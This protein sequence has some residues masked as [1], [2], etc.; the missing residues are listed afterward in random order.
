MISTFSV[1]IDCMHQRL[2][3]HYDALD[4][5]R[6]P[7][8]APPSPSG[9]RM[10][11]LDRLLS[12]KPMA[13]TT[14]E[15][16][17]I[18]LSKGPRRGRVRL[19]PSPILS[20]KRGPDG[21]RGDSVAPIPLYRPG[22]EHRIAT[23]AGL[24]AIRTLRRSKPGP[25]ASHRPAKLYLV[26]FDW[27]E[28]ARRFAEPESSSDSCPPVGTYS[29]QGGCARLIRCVLESGGL[30]PVTSRAGASLAREQGGWNIVWAT[31]VMKKSS[32]EDGK[33]Y[34][35]GNARPGGSLA[36]A[37]LP[38]ARRSQFPRSSHITRKDALARSVTVLSK[39]SGA[40]RLPAFLPTT[41]ILP[42]EA[43]AFQR[44]C[45]RRPGR[46]WIVKPAASSQGRGVHVTRYG[47]DGC[48]VREES[49]GGAPLPH[50]S[51]TLDLRTSAI[52]SSASLG[53]S[54]VPISSMLPPE[55]L[56]G[57]RS[58]AAGSSFTVSSYVERPLL[59][60][61]FKFDIRLYVAVTSFNPPRVYLHQHGLARFA[62]R[63]YGSASLQDRFVH[64]TNYS[65]NK[66]ADAFREAR[67]PDEAFGHKWGLPAL[68]ERWEADPR[69]G[70]EGAEYLWR[71]I[72]QVAVRTVLAAHSAVVRPAA[73]SGKGTAPS[74]HRE[75]DVEDEEDFLARSCGNA[76][77]LF[78][79]DVLVDESL[80]PWLLEVN[81][82]P[83]MAAEAPLDV[84]IK[85][86]VLSD[87]LNLACIPAN[88]GRSHASAAVA[89]SS[90]EELDRND[91]RSLPWA[92][93]AHLVSGQT[94]DELTDALIAELEYRRRGEYR[95]L[96]P[97]A[98]YPE[99]LAIFSQLIES[100]ELRRRAEAL[101]AYMWKAGKVLCPD[102]PEPVEAQRY[103]T[104]TSIV[105]KTVGDLS[106][107]PESVDELRLN[108]VRAF[109]A[110]T[111][112]C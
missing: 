22:R 99:S 96:M 108:A 38:L 92:V 112:P 90:S 59:L 85:S 83:S 23:G 21:V 58:L 84:E 20:P 91:S 48:P 36:S 105:R 80:Q 52:D 37:A 8:A 94:S 101:C 7:M 28:A 88:R 76:F 9:E 46:L 63:K 70:K 62:T 31:S 6:R 57:S 64:L 68:R 56:G 16:V 53:P 11:L 18:S 26:T 55:L 13:E 100:R 17:P 5:D 29:V 110:W 79:L 33:P 47:A 30:L 51:G 3:E 78:G 50:G 75:D 82:S 25:A 86:R 107:T 45:A 106:F 35:Q 103:M 72:D 42:A 95:R 44:A 27:R 40:I 49:R 104:S 24:A 109:R 89:A 69:I 10:S 71:Q 43:G 111:P 67:T 34:E 41:F 39:R 12:A 60:D 1:R 2:A 98:E 73:S 102:G 54:A 61:G 74:P 97:S 65:V 93:R 81:L 32:K 87:T 4:W 77:Q 19:T 14:G 15:R 66:H